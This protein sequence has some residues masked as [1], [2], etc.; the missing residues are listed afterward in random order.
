MTR[1]SPHL[2]LL[3]ALATLGHA[4]ADTGPEHAAALALQRDARDNQSTLASASLPL[5]ERS[6]VEL[7][8]GQNRTREAGLQQR[9]R[10]LQL[11]AGRRW[12]DWRGALGASHRRDGQR[13]R[14]TD[15]QAGLDW[16]GAQ[17]DA[18]LDLL[19]RDA[20]QRGSQPGAGGTGTPVEQRLKGPGLGLRGGASFGAARV[21]AGLTRNRYRSRTE[22]LAA[23]GGGLLGNVL[24]VRPS[25]VT[26]DEAAI[27]R[28][29]LAGAS[30]RFESM[31]LALETLSDKVLEQPGSLRTVQLKADIDLAPGWNLQPALGRS[32]DAQ[33]GANFGALTLSRRW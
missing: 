18:G 16:Q 23:P 1:S 33:S 19:Y 4:R 5:G 26:R 32:R 14:Q 13:L 29:V 27:S 9:S 3:L 30:W 2:A 20:R 6:W 8:L 24:G 15:W 22:Q 21:Y 10:V 12:G 7:G 11:A 31:S 25:L 17:F 28:S